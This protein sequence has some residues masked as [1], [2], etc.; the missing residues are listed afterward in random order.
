MKTSHLVKI[1]LLTIPAITLLYVFLLRDRIEGG[2]GIGGGS[3]DLT[4]TFTAIAI[5]LYLLVLNLFLLI[6]N[7]QANKFFLLGGGV[8]LMI[9]VI[10]AVRTF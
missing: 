3:Y 8:M 10:I 6:Q 2:T 7:A 4:K 1:I 9:T 5:G